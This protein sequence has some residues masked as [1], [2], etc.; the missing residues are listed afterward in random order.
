LGG[1]LEHGD[2]GYWANNYF[3]CAI[4]FFHLHEWIANALVGKIQVVVVP[5]R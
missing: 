5:I 4:L 1:N 2:Y 3:D